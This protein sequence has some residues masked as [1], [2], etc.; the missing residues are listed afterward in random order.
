MGGKIKTLKG[1]DIYKY[2][3]DGRTSIL[4][5]AAALSVMERL[6]WKLQRL[7]T[8]SPQRVKDFR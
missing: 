6:L 2:N 1:L 3:N 7:K 4:V 5:F 8:W